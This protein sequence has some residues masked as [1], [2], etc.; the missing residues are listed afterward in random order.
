MPCSR[1]GAIT[2]RRRYCCSAAR[3]G[4][5]HNDYRQPRAH[6]AGLL[7]YFAHR[8]T[9]AAA[10]GLNARIQADQG[11]RPRVPPPRL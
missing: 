10:E 9:N 3:H 4:P 2:N 5:G 1:G 11:L 7:T 6:P 8:I